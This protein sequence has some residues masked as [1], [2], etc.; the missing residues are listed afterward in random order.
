MRCHRA[1][2]DYDSNSK[3]L[4]AELSYWA[5]VIVDGGKDTIELTRENSQKV[6]MLEN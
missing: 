3:S 1:M 4:E 5:G 2:C 6:W